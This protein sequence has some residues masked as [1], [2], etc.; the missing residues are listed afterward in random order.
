M[1]D[2]AIAV[3]LALLA[4]LSWGFSAVLVRLGLRDMSTSTGR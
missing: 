3:L 4:A 1:G 2:E